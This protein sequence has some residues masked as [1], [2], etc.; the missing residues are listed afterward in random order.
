MECGKPDD[1]VLKDLERRQ[2]AILARLESLKLEVST[3]KS[4]KPKV[5][6]VVL[7]WMYPILIFENLFLCCKDT[8]IIE[9]KLAKLFE[10]IRKIERLFATKTPLQIGTKS[11]SSAVKDIVIRASPQY[12]PHSVP[13]LCSQLQQSSLNVFTS[14]HIHSSVKCLP[15]S[16]EDFLPMS[17]CNSRSK[18]NLCVTLIW[19]DGKL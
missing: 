9:D 16:L 7:S 10:T 5:I 8:N 18:A 13:I 14:A 19:K 4:G 2:E 1:Q 11:S 12:P 17:N 6:I 15:N 3:L